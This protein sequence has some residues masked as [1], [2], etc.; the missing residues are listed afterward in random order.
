MFFSIYGCVDFSTKTYQEV[1]T[2]ISQY[3]KPHELY[4]E[5]GIS[6]I[7]V[8]PEFQGKVITTTL[9]GKK[10]ISN[11]WVNVEAFK[12]SGVEVAKI[13]GEERLWFG[14]LG[15]QHS[16]YYQQVKPL[17]EE[18][19]QVPKAIRE[20]SYKMIH[21]DRNSISLSKKIAL[22]NFI[23]TEFLI[24]VYRKIKLLEPSDI[25]KILNIS[26]DNEIQFVAYESFNTIINS[27]EKAWSKKT[28]LVSIWSA[29]MF[30]GTPNTV[31]IIPIEST[32]KS[33]AILQYFNPL[34]V[35]RL[36]RNTNVLLY[37]T[38][39]SYRSKIGI[40]FNVAP[41]IF[42]SYS[43]ELN[44]LT[45]VN[46][47]KPN[48]NQYTNSHVSYQDD[49]Y[50]NGEVIPIYNNANGFYELESMSPSVELAPGGKISH[51]HRV[52]HLS[53]DKN[54]LSA[55]SEALLKTPLSAIE[56]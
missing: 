7:L 18:N 3:S 6:R 49:P 12:P 1:K 38:D 41:N 45:I 31:T 5:D 55:I 11:G 14:P 28:G 29:N 42:G 15:S 51:F 44:R 23:G 4:S 10:G 40:P 26:L 32:L 8:S 36:K 47:K 37:K 2:L 35:T 54:K 17:D 20:G 50:S 48:L 33:D 9:N 46:Y 21:A 19:W 24:D 56:F 39:A 30:A 53:G 43:K 25:E 27:D 16:F 34:G 13:G 22:T 52:F